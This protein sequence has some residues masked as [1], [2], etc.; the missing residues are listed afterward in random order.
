MPQQLQKLI[1][2]VKDQQGNVTNVEFTIAG[3][4]GSISS[5][6]D[7]DDVD[8]TNPQDGQ[9]LV[10]SAADSAWINATLVATQGQIGSASAGTAISADDI[11]AWSA[12]TAAS[13]SVS[14]E[15][16]TFTNG[17]APSLSYTAKSIPNITVTNVNVVSDIS[18]S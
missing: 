11:T 9:I 14:G 17:T 16:V 12:G 3:G 18:I 4:G 8:L 13:A 7:I 6:G 10:Y 2:P 5:I 1:L 15:K